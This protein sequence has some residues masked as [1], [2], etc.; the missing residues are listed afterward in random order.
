MGRRITPGHA[1]GYPEVAV[2]VESSPPLD[3]VAMD[4]RKKGRDPSGR[5]PSRLAGGPYGCVT[6]SPVTTAS[7]LCA[8]RTPY[9]PSVDLSFPAVTSA[10]LG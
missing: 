4:G 6:V 1:G 9:T 10:D 5:A 8:N 2:K 3:G 7:V